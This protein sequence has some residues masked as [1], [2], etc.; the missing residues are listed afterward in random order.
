MAKPSEHPVVVDMQ[1][2][3]ADV[4]NNVEEAISI[5][6]QK[7]DAILREL[8]RKGRISWHTPVPVDRES[9]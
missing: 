5:H 6:N 7:L 8:A 4:A 3:L 1:K 9:A 2:T